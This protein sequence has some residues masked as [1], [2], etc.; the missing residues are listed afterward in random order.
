MVDLDMKSIKNILDVY[1]FYWQQIGK[2]EKFINGFMYYVECIL[3][4]IVCIFMWPLILYGVYYLIM[5]VI[6]YINFNLYC[7]I[8]L[9][10]YILWI[11]FHKYAGAVFVVMWLFTFFVIGAITEKGPAHIYN[12]FYWGDH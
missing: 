10:L 11:A 6:F 3:S 2:M 9:N 12:I 8:V 4:L 1:Y 7:N 5:S